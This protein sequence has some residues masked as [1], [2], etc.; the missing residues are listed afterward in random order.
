MSLSISAFELPG[1][2][3]RRK[4]STA[5]LP[6]ARRRS[7][8]AEIALVFADLAGIYLTWENEMKGIELTESQVV[9]RWLLRGAHDGELKACRRLLVELLQVRFPTEVSADLTAMIDKQDNLELLNAWFQ[10]AARAHSF[11]QF[12]EFLKGGAS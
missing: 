5:E 11:A 8:V 10:A 4:E 7:E 6:E 12:L 3:A 2:L 9:N 1:C